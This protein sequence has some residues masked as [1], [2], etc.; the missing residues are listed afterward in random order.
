MLQFFA[1]DYHSI[2]NIFEI[3]FYTQHNFYIFNTN[4]GLLVLLLGRVLCLF[5][6]VFF[7]HLHYSSQ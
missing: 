3:F 5:F 4:V 1:V 7:T 6:A 2:V